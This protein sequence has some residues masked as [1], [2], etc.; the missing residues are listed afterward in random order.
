[1]SSQ[2]DESKIRSRHVVAFLFRESYKEKRMF[3]A[4]VTAPVSAIAIGTVIPYIIS[5]ILAN[6][7]QGTI[8]GYETKALS[9]LAAAAIIGIVANRI[10]FVQLLKSQALTLQ[11]LQ[12]NVFD[13][14]LAKDR[15]YFADRMSGKIVS[16]VMSLQSSMI[17]FQDLL[18]ITA[19]PLTLN[20][21]FGI[22]LVSSKSWVLGLGL[23]LM[24]IIVIASAFY[25]SYKRA[26]LREAR[27]RMRRELYGYFADV[28]ANSAAVK[29]FGNER[30]EK[31][32]HDKLNREFA[33]TRIRDWTRVSIDANNRIIVILLL[34]IVFIALIIRLVGN[35]PALLAT[36][37]FAFSFTIT[38]SQKLF[39]ISSVIKGLE[40]A[41]TDAAAAIDILDHQPT[42]IDASNAKSLKTSGGKIDFDNVTFKYKDNKDS[43]HLFK[44]LNFAIKPG[45]K[46][47]LVGKSGGGKTSITNLLLRFND[48]DEGSIRIDGQD[49]S[50][51]TQESL[52]KHIAYVPQEPLLF[53]RSIAENISYGKPN[54]TKSEIEAVARL[55]HAHS[56]VKELPNKYETL[57]GERGVKLSGGQRQR[58][59]IARAMLKDAPILVLDEATSALD[60]ESEVLIQDALWKLMEGRTAIVIAHRLSTIQK[61]DRI[62]VM[63][64][65]K[66]IEQGTHAELLAHKGTYASLWGHQSGGFLD[67]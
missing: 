60:S 62:I 40:T 24:T 7:A 8:T 30:S 25:Y 23:L 64:E 48:I 28:I 47:G 46:V 2:P 32:Q 26:P 61:M 45:E 6:L 22:L 3:I 50:R 66:I 34:Q 35:N 58:V 29:M 9:A 18:T 19:L 14:L 31:K 44:N 17:Q 39:D 38:L 52:R 27:H 33:Q 41:I 16:D 12:S 4:I 11:R 59:A 56:F 49:I 15:A 10:S 36:G 1:M 54:A 42:I 65:G 37:I 67:D 5:R 20:L 55:A 63:D 53:H 13:S 43:K 57:V 51:V 21:I